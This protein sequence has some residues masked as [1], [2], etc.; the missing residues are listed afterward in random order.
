MSKE[1]IAMNFKTNINCG[2]CVAIVKPVLDAAAGI[3]KWQVDTNVKDKILTLV[4]NGI[5]EA[6]VID[7]VQ[8]AGYK[9]EKISQ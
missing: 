4:S 9:I 7:L 1:K 3:E 8:K 6:E 5:T 2:G